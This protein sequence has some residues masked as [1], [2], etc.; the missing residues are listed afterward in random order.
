MRVTAY[1]K[2][3]YIWAST[4]VL[5]KFMGTSKRINYNEVEKKAFKI[6]SGRNWLIKSV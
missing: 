1:F 2:S 3:A 5:A 4:V 6:H